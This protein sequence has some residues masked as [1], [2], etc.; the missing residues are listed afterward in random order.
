[1]AIPVPGDES[2]GAMPRKLLDRDGPEA[3]LARAAH[4]DEQA[5]RELL[6]LYTRRVYAM[7]RSRLGRDDLAEEI[8]Q[9]VFATVATKMTGGGY[10]EQGRFESWLFRI[11]MNRVRD[12]IRRSKHRPEAMDLA[13]FSLAETH[14]GVRADGVDAEDLL[15]LRNAIATLGET[16]R[17][18]IELRHHAQMSFKQIS[19]LLD[20]P[21]GTILARHHRAL[22]KLRSELEA[23]QSE[24][25]GS[26]L[27]RGS[28]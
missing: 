14:D 25:S 17:E 13:E 11:T 23:G 10:A 6:G 5:W 8:T 4:G 27:K 24:K 18:I 28:T 9:S 1:M 7:A 16:D 20:V 12:E 21:M 2:A 22:A 26:A 3:L 15:A 19:S